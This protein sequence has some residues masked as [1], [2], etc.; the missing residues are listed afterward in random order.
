MFRRT[1]PAEG[2][3]EEVRQG[4]EPAQ[5][6]PPNPHAPEDEHNIDDPFAVGDGETPTDKEPEEAQP[7]WQRRE[8]GGD[9]EADDKSAEPQYGS[10][11]EE[12]NAWNNG[13]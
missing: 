4:Y 6:Q 12:R 9:D 8:Y 1:Y 7:H 2:Q 11:N 3:E 10:F 13:Q 5:V